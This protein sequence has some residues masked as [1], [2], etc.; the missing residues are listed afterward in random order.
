MKLKKLIA[1]GL[2]GMMIFLAGCTGT[3]GGGGATGNRD[4]SLKLSYYAGGYGDA[5]LKAIAKDYMEVNKDVEIVL[6]PS[7]DNGTALAEIESGSSPNDVY[8]I[9][10]P[11]FGK[12]KFLLDIS[13]V[14]EMK[15]YGE[16]TLIKDKMYEGMTEFYNEDGK[17]Y[18]MPNTTMTGWNWV[19]N[20]TVMDEIYGE[21]KY[22]IPR[23]TNEMFTLGDD[24]FNNHGTFLTLAA[25][26]DTQ[27][28]DYSHYAFSMW[29][30]QMT[31][32]EGYEKYMGGQ[33][34]DAASGSY[35]LAESGPLNVSTNKNAIEK[36]YETVY[37]LCT[38]GNYYLYN[39]SD[40]LNFKGADQVFYGGGYG[41]NRAKVAMMY[42]GAWAETEVA[43][44]IEDGI[45]QDQELVAMKLPVMSAIIDRCETIKDEATLIATIEHVD[46]NAEAPA[47]VSEADIAIIRE[48][49]NLVCENVCRNI[50]VP[51][52]TQNAEAVKEFLT[53]LASDRAQKI[54]AQNTEGINMLPY[55][56]KPTV[57]DM[58]FEY[59]GY[60]KSIYDKQDEAIVVDVSNSTNTFYQVSSMSWF[61]DKNVSN[62]MLD[63]AVFSGKAAKPS[64]IYQNTYDYYN[65]SQWA[66]YIENYKLMTGK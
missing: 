36:T 21:G 53:Y 48:A 52:N 10:V 14:Y 41:M 54:S 15:A 62:G 33:Y 56:Y 4:V 63:K 13:D 12:S 32:V 59:S 47:G 3:G 9:E 25:M 45:V 6:V 55:G 64:E 34:Y 57:E 37:K 2:A 49:R 19:Y 46:G 35:K 16:D 5:W 39:D 27:G 42:I 20:K 51:S 18:Q 66:T 23:T 7:Y 24:L 44:L 60:V 61:H 58:G 11:M 1:A 40:S 43:D 8:M 30:A 65:S 29:F 22:T 50:V 28:G 38:K 26:A 31:G 17:Y